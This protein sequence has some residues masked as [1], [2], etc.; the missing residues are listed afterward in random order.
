MGYR[1]GSFNIKKSA[2][3]DIKDRDFYDL[4]NRMIAREGIDIFAFQEAKSLYF[5][6]NLRRNLPSCW[7]GETIGNSEL[8]FVWNANR[9]RECSPAQAPRIFTDYPGRAR[10]RMERDPAYGRFTPADYDLNCEFRLIN[11]HIKHGGDDSPGSVAV[12]EFECNLALGVIY[13]TIDKP[14]RGKDGNFRSIFTVVLGDYNLDCARCDACAP[15]SVRTFQEE[16]T[17]LM[18]EEPGY[19]NSYDH[20]SY[21]AKHYA[22]VPRRPPSRIDAVEGLPYFAGDFTG[23]Q[24]KISDH[25]PVK[26][27]IF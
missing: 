24:K 27:E 1:I 2:R 8:A 17:T 23:Y 18:K 21:D 6:R 25:V 13:E 9:V 3:D 15:G 4:I 7:R 11:I 10:D 5:V 14:P 26:L 16:K 22:G 19:K 12:R 20:F